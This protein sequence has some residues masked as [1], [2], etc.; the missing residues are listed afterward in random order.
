MI[1]LLLILAIASSVTA[2]VRP[3][4]PDVSVTIVGSDRARGIIYVQQGDRVFVLQGSQS[5]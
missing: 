4:A 5:F 2:F 1:R 3:A